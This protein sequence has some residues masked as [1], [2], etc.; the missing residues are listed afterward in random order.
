VLET[1]LNPTLYHGY[2]KKKNFFEG[3]Y[4]K[5]STPNHDR[6]LV[7]IPGSAKGKDELDQH[8][9]IQVL[10][11]KTQL[12]RYLKYEVT[13]F[14]VEKNPFV[15]RVGKNKF[16]MERLVVDIKS[17]NL[18]VK[19]ELFFHKLVSWP[20][21]TL[22]PGSM[23]YFNYLTFMECYSH[24]NALD[25]TVSGKLLID[26]EEIDFNGGK[27]Y[28]EKNWGRSFPSAYIWV[29]SNFF[30]QKDVSLSCSVGK[31]PFGKLKF[32][33]FLTA[34]TNGKKV[35]RF[36]TMNHSKMQLTDH[37]V[38]FDV[39]FKNRKFELS[40][41]TIIDEQ[42]YITCLGP[43]LG[44]MNMKVLESLSSK[45]NVVLKRRKTQEVILDVTSDAVALERMGDLSV[46]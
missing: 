40:I 46:L 12:N 31:I 5:V 15:A 22:N 34:I 30:N 39:V 35:Y 8:A 29:Q 9:F 43:R 23:G 2:H 41:Q 21:T 36:T 44:E 17:K 28:S 16:S 20:S 32:T 3:W 6:T 14:H 11:S 45:A 4:F 10:D 18:S 33:G 19:G 25:G 42:D 38:N 24:V 1:I 37:G 27:F 13:A 7:F 26:G